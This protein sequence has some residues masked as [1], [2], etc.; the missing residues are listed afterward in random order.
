M[1]VPS[2]FFSSQKCSFVCLLVQCD[3]GAGEQ[4]SGV[5]ASCATAAAGKRSVSMLS[6]PGSRAAPCQLP[7]RPSVCRRA[8]VR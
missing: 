1:L 2:V 5:A 8:F 4:R 3:R 6:F 7:R